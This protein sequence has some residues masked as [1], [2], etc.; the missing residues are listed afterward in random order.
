MSKKTVAPP[1]STKK[2]NLEGL[3]STECPDVLDLTDPSFLIDISD[4]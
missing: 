3:L 4:P 1:E 2:L